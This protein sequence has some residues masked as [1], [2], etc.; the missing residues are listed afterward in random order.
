MKYPYFQNY[1]GVQLTEEEYQDIK[2]PY[3]EMY[4]HVTLKTVQSGTLLGTVLFGPLLALIR[5]DTRNMKGL[6]T[7][8]SKA[9]SVGAGVGLLAGKY[10]IFIF[11]YKFKFFN[12]F[13]YNSFITNK[14][15]LEIKRRH[16]IMNI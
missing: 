4:T 15:K 6:I 2:Y 11:Y 1:A 3:L 13:T 16:I 9:G 14:L 10:F 12:C 8:I 7:K 5:K